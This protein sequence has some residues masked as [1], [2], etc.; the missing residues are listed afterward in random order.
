M[1]VTTLGTL[2][3]LGILRATGMLEEMLEGIPVTIGTVGT[4]GTIETI[5]STE[6]R[7]LP[8]KPLTVE[9]CPGTCRLSL[10]QLRWLGNKGIVRSSKSLESLES[11]R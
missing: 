11:G 10:E 2:G 6:S 5:E 1:N 4:H 7:V 8:D 3:F 9:I